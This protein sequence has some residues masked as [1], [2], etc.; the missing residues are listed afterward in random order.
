[1]ALVKLPYL[2]CPKEKIEHGR[3]KQRKNKRK[4]KV[5]K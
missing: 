2:L 3:K 1:M 4:G 5:A